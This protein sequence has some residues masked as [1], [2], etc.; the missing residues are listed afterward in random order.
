MITFSKVSK[1]SE[2][3]LEPLRVLIFLLDFLDVERD[4]EISQV[5]VAEALGMQASNV[6]RAIALLLEKEVLEAGPK[7]GR[8][9]SYRL[10]HDLF[11][12]HYYDLPD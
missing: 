8:S 6:S 3:T 12:R 10:N 9:C 2:L 4:R 11:A 7:V 1:D 5:E